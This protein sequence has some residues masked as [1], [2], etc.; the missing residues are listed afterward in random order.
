MFFSYV[1]I[2]LHIG[3]T[4]ALLETPTSGTSEFELIIQSN[5]TLTAVN[6]REN[7]ALIDKLSVHL[8]IYV[9]NHHQNKRKLDFNRQIC[10]DQNLS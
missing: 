10:S 4:R 7:L 1:G 5:L 9:V 2:L 3:F 6:I 8:H